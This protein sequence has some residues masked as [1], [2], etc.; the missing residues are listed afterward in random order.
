MNSRLLLKFL[1]ITLLVIG[2]TILI[3][4]L[5]IDLFAADYFSFLMEKYNVPKEEVQQIF[6]DAVHRYLILAG[7]ASLFLGGVLGFLLIRRVL[8]P[9]YQMIVLTKKIAQGD[10]TAKVQIS[11]Q[12]E[13]RQLAVAFNQMTDSLQRTEQLR[14]TM[15]LDI[16]HE[17][18]VPLT[19]MRGYLEALSDGVL[20]PSRKNFESLHEETLRLASLTE[21]LLQLSNAD[22]A[23]ST[24][25]RQPINLQELLAQSVDLFHAQFVG[26]AITVEMHFPEGT[27]AVMADPDKLAQVVQNLL[28]NAWQ[29][30]PQGGN[31]RIA[32]EHLPGR[33]KVIFAN[34]GEGVAEEDLPF[35]FERFYRG[36]KSRS[37]EYGG[38]GIGLAIV[39]GL[40]EAHGGQVGA[41][42]SSAE[43]RVWFTLPA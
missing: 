33:I 23:Q 8:G 19:N 27:A 9:L 21:D 40:I 13:V 20:P 10:Y 39:K 18:R 26:K 1:L 14:N 41:E 3:V 7:L 22:V 32:I 34:T 6:L 29:Y 24:L 11:S 30:T 28:R 43:I 37:R 15:V 31:I 17:L 36:E 16:A 4:W 35:L 5:A 25:R 2:V 38:A 12:D 42:S